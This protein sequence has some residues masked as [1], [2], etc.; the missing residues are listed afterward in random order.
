[1][2]GSLVSES[3]TV[4]KMA[5]IMELDKLWATGISSSSHAVKAILLSTP[6][7]TVALRI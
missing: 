7:T 2:V 3:R 6:T 5:K 1:M 4:V